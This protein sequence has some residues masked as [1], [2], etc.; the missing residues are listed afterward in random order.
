MPPMLSFISLIVQIGADGYAVCHTSVSLEDGDGTSGVGVAAA[1][2]VSA[3]SARAWASAA[4]Q[5]QHQ[6]QK[7]HQQRQQRHANDAL[8]RAWG[9]RGEGRRRQEEEEGVERVGGGASPAR[10]ASSSPPPLTEVRLR[11]F[12][13]GRE[14]VASWSRMRVVGERR[15]S[16]DTE[17]KRIYTSHFWPSLFF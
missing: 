10:P 3:A 15:V 17:D 12:R 7:R 9:W 14:A 8:M 6:H 4:S 16:G 11:R 2:A 1:A 13:E 5:H